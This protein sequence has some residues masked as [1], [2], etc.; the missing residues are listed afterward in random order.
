VIKIVRDPYDLANAIS[1]LMLFVSDIVKWDPD[2]LLFLA[3]RDGRKREREAY[4]QEKESLITR[5]PC[6][7][8]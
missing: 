1:R 3:Q 4:G 7:I 8:K 6:P 5:D 2:P